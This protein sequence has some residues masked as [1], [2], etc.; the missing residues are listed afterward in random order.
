[1][2]T[3]AEARGIDGGDPPGRALLAAHGVLSSAASMPA[4]P[5][6]H[7]DEQP[8]VSDKTVVSRSARTAAVRGCGHDAGV[9]YV[10][11]RYWVPGN[12]RATRSVPVPWPDEPAC[13]S[14]P[15]LDLPDVDQV[16]VVLARYGA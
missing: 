7:A 10:R 1:M 5:P 2:S 11:W 13:W 12:G 6:E 15:V 3:P 14:W 4:G 8:G 9:T 16:P